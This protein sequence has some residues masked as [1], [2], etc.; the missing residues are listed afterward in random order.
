MIYLV[1]LEQNDRI[2]QTEKL[3]EVHLIG[4]LDAK[5]YSCIKEDIVTDGVIITDKHNIL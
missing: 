5:I 4:R 3:N 1:V 2:L